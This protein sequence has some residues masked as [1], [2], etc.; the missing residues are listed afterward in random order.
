MSINNSRQRSSIDNRG[1]DG[2]S[3][4]GENQGRG[5][6]N[7]GRG[8]KDTRPTREGIRPNSENGNPSESINISPQNVY[9]KCDLKC[10][11]MFDYP[12]TS[13]VGKNN[14]VLLSFTCDEPNTSPVEFNKKKYN[15][16]KIIIVA[17]SIHLFNDEQTDAEIL[18][19]HNPILGGPSLIIGIPIIQSSNTN[20]G[21][22]NI[23]DMINAMATNAPA[24]GETTEINISNFTLNN[25]IPKKPFFSYMGPDMQRSPAA[26]IMFGY[27]EAIPLTSS[28]LNSLTN[29]IKSFDIKT[30]GKY[31]FFNKN[32]PNSYVNKDGIYISC[33]PTGAS[34][35]SVIVDDGSGSSDTNYNLGSIFKNETVQTI[36]KFILFILLFLALFKG[37]NTAY[38]H[39]TANP[40]KLTGLPFAKK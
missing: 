27:L 19:I 12:T 13:L 35:E 10:E 29:I 31:L 6:S 14:G 2:S 28:T 36:I 32:G 15:V 16:E 21:T 38:N 26:Y 22:A 17:P 18:I 34:D 39:L 33:Q 25:I 7:G 4:R 40:I 20:T 3:G 23:T 9:G 24:Q 1:R 30:P 8:S 5:R 11:Y 37:L